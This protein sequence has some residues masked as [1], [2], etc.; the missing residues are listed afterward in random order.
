MNKYHVPHI[1]I[2]AYN[3]KANGVVERGH[4]IIREAILKSCEGNT[5]K[6][7][8]YVSHAFFAN[9]VTTRRQTGYSPYFLLHGVD[10]VLPFDLTE[11]SFLVQGFKANLSTTE[12]LALRIRQLEKRDE[13]IAQAAQT[14][15]RN[16]IKSKDQFEKRFK[17]RM[18]YDSYPPGSLVLV[19]NSAKEKSMDRKAFNRY[20]GPYQVVRRTAG[21]SYILQEVDGARMRTGFA[22][23]RVIPYIQRDSKEL[24]YLARDLDKVNKSESEDSGEDDATSESSTDSDRSMK[25]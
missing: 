23:F 18:R 19:R 7:P 21:G 24:K 8:D 14:L 10:P 5:Q 20:N 9:N 4:F 13:D 2:S 6:W 1:K 3:S 16:R 22:A 11:A 12:L 15:R 17:A 25:D